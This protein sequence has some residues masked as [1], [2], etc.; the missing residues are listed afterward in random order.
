[1]PVQIA[2]YGPRHCTDENTIH[3]HEVGRLLA[4]AGAVVISGG[5]TGVMAAATT[6]ARAENGLVIGGSWGTLSEIALVK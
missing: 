3:A 4:R 6:G 5:G 1:M 2:V